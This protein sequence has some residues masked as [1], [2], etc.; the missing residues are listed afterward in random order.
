MKMSAKT[1]LSASALVFALSMA[2]PSTAQAEG[3]KL[4]GKS[5]ALAYAPQNTATENRFAQFENEE[6]MHELNDAWLGMPAFSNDGKIIGFIEDAYLD[7]DDEITELLVSINDQ[8]IAV[9]VDGTRA[10]LT[11]TKVAIALTKT[12]I[13]SLEREVGYQIASR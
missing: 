3:F 9:Y 10:T 1:I 11:D 8:K 2:N 5:I 13:A 7:E 6:D 12:Q 4:F